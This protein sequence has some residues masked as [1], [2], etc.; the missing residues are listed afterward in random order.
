MPRSVRPERD[1]AFW[2]ALAARGWRRA[3]TAPIEAVCH[4]YGIPIHRK[5]TYYRRPAYTDGAVWLSQQA[6]DT[7]M[8]RTRGTRGLRSIR[9]NRDDPT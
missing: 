3:R 7:L 8:M 5:G 9:S 4:A 6:Y 1:D 2:Q